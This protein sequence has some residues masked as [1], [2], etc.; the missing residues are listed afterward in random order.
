[1]SFILFLAILLNDLFLQMLIGVAKNRITQ[2]Q[3][4]PIQNFFKN[5]VLDKMKKRIQSFVYG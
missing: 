5:S 3:G 1:M 2:L 4:Q